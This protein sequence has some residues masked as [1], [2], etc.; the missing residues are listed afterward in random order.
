M[1]SSVPSA[2]LPY[3]PRPDRRDEMLDASGALRPG[4]AALH[5]RLVA[6]GPDGLDHVA[7]RIRRQLHRHGTTFQIHGGDEER[8]ALD[9]VPL[10]VPGLDWSGLGLAL[11]QRAL[12]IEAVLADLHGER[13]LLRQGLVPAE[14]LVAHDGLLL[15]TLDA[16]APGGRS[17]VLYAADVVRSADGS[18]RLLSDHVDDPTGAGYVLENRTVLSDVVPELVRSLGVRRIA[19]WFEGL[20]RALVA[21]AP[22][23]V[24]EPRIVLLTAGPGRETAFEEAL[25]ARTLGYTLVQGA[26]LAVRGGSVFLKSIGGLEPVHVIL[27]RLPSA[28][29]DPLELRPGS[30]GVPGLVEAVRRGTVTVVNPL[31][32][33]V[34]ENPA[35][36]ATIA[37][38]TRTVLGEDPL[39]EPAPTWWC[40]D[41][42]GRSH[43]LAH[44]DELVI[45]P[46]HRAPGRHSVFGRS[47]SDEARADLRARIQARPHLWVGQA[48][49]D[50]P[51]APVLDESGALV[52]G[53]VVQRAFAVADED[54][55]GFLESALT[56]TAASTEVL[57]PF[58]GGASKDTWVIDTSQARARRGRPL[59]ARPQI[60]LRASITSH[61]AEAM[62]WVGRNLERADLAPR[63]VLAVQGQLDDWP[64]LR[65]EADGA[66]LATTAGALTDLVGAPRPAR[67]AG[68]GGGPPID[69]LVTDALV[70]RDRPRSLVT[71][72]DYL[73][74]GAR[75]V[76]ELF[77]SETWRN[78]SEL[79]DLTTRLRSATGGDA[80]ELALAAL[81][82]LSAISGLLTESMVR[83]PGWRFLDAGRRIERALVLAV[84]LRS[85]LVAPP[86]PLVAAPV[87]ELVLLAWDSLVAYR[88]RYRSDVVPATLV[89]LLV[90]D[91][92]NPRS[93]AASLD[94]L[95]EDLD[96]LPGLAGRAPTAL[97]RHRRL[98]VAV[99]GA[100]ADA[101]VAV[102]DGR[103]PVL[104]GLLDDVTTELR[105]LA[106]EL[107]LGYFAHVR[108][109]AVGGRPL[110]RQTDPRAMP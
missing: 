30:G 2:V 19:P 41:P 28:D 78:L 48:E 93:L 44:L 57:T 12:V 102:E 85:A 62:F 92:T 51:T 79:A 65:H 82:S 87:H 33:G 25:L 80:E 76:R 29:A 7:T 50:L 106:S 22:P 73:T 16:P 5:E 32:A 70:D 105:A 81:T 97:D 68:E 10:V 110:Q 42:A 99:A 17:L 43:V 107:E 75:S 59:A 37:G 83:D 109:A 39:I 100:S 89:D 98:R 84:T 9:A 46:I 15:P 36:L 56:R 11:T 23:D 49:L 55:F 86:P 72:L 52:P 69:E 21:A 101:L 27:R 31:G 74:S 53:H 54:G 94:R 104:A 45:K 3:S 13:R 40:S 35:L 88:R 34:A 1:T 96:A 8:W 47:L 64:D 90:A 66:W 38:L 95:G 18:F 61:T 6:L 77:S 58:R 71:S 24:A 67:D 108:T 20:R 4:W 63:L 14:A 103:R 60:D 26:D 91:G